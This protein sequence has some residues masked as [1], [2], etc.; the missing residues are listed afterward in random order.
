MKKLILFLAMIVLFSSFVYAD[1]ETATLETLDTTTGYD[2]IVGEVFNST[3]TDTVTIT[4]TKGSIDTS[5]QCVL[6]NWDTKTLMNSSSFSGDD[7]EVSGS[8]TSGVEYLIGTNTGSRTIHYATTTNYPFLSTPNGEFEVTKRGYKDASNNW[9]TSTTVVHLEQVVFEYQEIGGAFEVTT[10]NLFN[11]SGIDSF[12]VN[13]TNS[14]GTTSVSTTNGTV[15]F[16]QGTELADLTIYDSTYFPVTITDYN[17]T[18]N[19]DQPLYQAKLIID[20]YDALNMTD[21]ANFNFTINDSIASQFNTSNS[22]NK[23]TFLVNA[24]EYSYTGKAEGFPNNATGTVSIS[25]FETKEITVNFTLGG[26][27]IYGPFN[28]STV[29]NYVEFD[30]DCTDPS[31]INVSRS[32]SNFQEITSGYNYTFNTLGTGFYAQIDSDSCSW[33]EITTSQLYYLNGTVKDS[34]G[35]GF[36]QAIVYAIRQESDDQYKNI[37]DDD[38]MFSIP[39]PL[40]GNYTIVGLKNSTLKPDS[41]AFVEIT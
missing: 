20:T 4:A 5:T 41:D 29:F 1:I 38:G 37:T 28:S 33:V 35:N 3:V 34:S 32:T 8:I 25:L 13:L 40:A 7:C 21:I 2:K 9:V 23:T 36:S 26:I 18:T 22:S 6:Y 24:D 14:T 27:N 17:T 16:S 12:T 30:S 39:V 31:Q 10:Y 15:Y 19:L 11:G